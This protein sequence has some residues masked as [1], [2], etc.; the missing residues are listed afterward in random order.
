[1]L[2]SYEQL[3]DKQPRVLQLLTSSLKKERLSHAYLFYG[4]KG[5]KKGAY[6]RLLAKIYLC[7][8]RGDNMAPCEKCNNCVRIEH[9]NHPDVHYVQSE[10]A[11]IKTEQIQ[12][13]QKEYA[14]SGMESARKVFIIEHC[15]LMTVQAANRMLKTIEEPLPGILTILTTEK[16]EAV[17]PTIQSRAQM[18]PFQEPTVESMEV[19][20]VAAGVPQYLSKIILQ[21]TTDLNE[22]IDMGKDSSFADSY[23]L[24]LQLYETLESNGAAAYLMIQTS[25][26]PH[27]GTKD[28][29]QNILG[30]FLLYFVFKDILYRRLGQADRCILQE[31]EFFQNTRYTERVLFS[32]LEEIQLA[33][34]KIQRN[35]NIQIVL[36][37]LMLYLQEV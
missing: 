24:V 32:I 27:F 6:A 2:S 29:E 21:I 25:W 10:G 30:L 35:F 11:H 16:K 5:T 4:N 7:S 15:D 23:R 34:K 20:L 33:Q 13:L 28:R 17:L 18:I 1:M 26:L 19:E 31:T 9:N 3:K 8:N 12:F 36:E 22:A 14:Y 37:N